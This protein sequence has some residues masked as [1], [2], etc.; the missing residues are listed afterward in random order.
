MAIGAGASTSVNDRCIL[1]ANE[2]QVDQSNGSGQTSL[3]LR[4]SA[5]VRWRIAVSTAGELVV[6]P[7]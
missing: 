5:N 4:D 2:V 1:K 3:I 6:S 7:A